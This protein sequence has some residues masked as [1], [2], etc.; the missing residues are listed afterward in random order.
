VNASFSSPRAS[1]VAVFAALLAATACYSPSITPGGIPC[2]RANR[3]YDQDCP[4]G[5]S[6][7]SDNRCWPPG[8]GPGVDGGVVTDARIDGATDMVVTPPDAAM[9]SKPEVLV[10]IVMPM[11]CT[12]AGGPTCDPV[13]QTGC[14]RCDQ[15]CSVN[16]ST[17][18]PTCNVPST[19]LARAEG[20]GCTPV[21][22]GTAA[23]TDNCSPGLVCL[24]S[25]LCGNSCTKFCNANSDCPNSE[26]SRTLP[27][28]KKYCDVPVV[29]CNPVT[30]LGPMGCADSARGCYVSATVPDQTR[31]ECAG[32]QTE[33]RDCTFSRDCFPGLVCADPT[34]LGL[35]NCQRSCKLTGPKSGCL[36][37]EMCVPIKGSQTYGFCQPKTL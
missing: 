7:R 33:G 35:F 30:P 6:C 25:V 27:G 19:G 16:T 2:G 36:S 5:Y 20:E 24:P 32:S 28:G 9:E 34:G 23:Q 12:S 8:K 29:T 14:P 22:Q 31:C 4:K 1:L 26:C 10:C 15:K 13:C 3:L 17:G 21:S 18:D 11:N 37:A